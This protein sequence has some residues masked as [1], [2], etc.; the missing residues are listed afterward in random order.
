MEMYP[1]RLRWIYRVVHE[2]DWAA[3]RIQFQCPC[4]N[5][6]REARSCCLNS[7]RKVQTGTP[8][9]EESQ[10]TESQDDWG[11]EAYGWNDTVK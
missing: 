6:R 1:S 10:E 2:M 7:S 9:A 3:V 8:G 11:I 4:D 5:H